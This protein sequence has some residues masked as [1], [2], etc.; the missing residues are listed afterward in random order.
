M[1]NRRLIRSKVFQALYAYT[2]T[3]DPSLKQ[4]ISY[5]KDSL[6][7]VEKNFLVFLHFPLEFIEFLRREMDPSQYKYLPT[8][9]DIAVHKTLSLHGTFEDL[10]AIENLKKYAEKPYFRWQEEFEL[11]RSLYQTIQGTKFFKDL[12]QSEQTRVDQLNFL[13]SFYEHLTYSHAEFDHKMEEFEMHWEDERIPI[14]N[15][16]RKMFDQSIEKNKIELPSLSKNRIEDMEFA[17]ELF[18]KSITLRSEYETLIDKNTPGWDKD[19]IAKA[20]LLLMVIALTE[21]LNFPHIP[22][23]V[24][25]NEY[26][27]LAKIYSTPQSSRFMNGILDKLVAQLKEEGKVSK[28]GRGL[29]E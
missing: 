19:R 7:G 15:A 25:L 22:I 26:L 21:I 17:T 8:E 14:S 3:E 29:I 28:K 10:M 27:E 2:Q 5:L 9:N 20:D 4:S 11:L 23:K 6:E 12:H 18:Q 24:S 1:L 16:V 13:R